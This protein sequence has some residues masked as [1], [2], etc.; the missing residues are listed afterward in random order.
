MGRVLFGVLR[1]FVTHFS[2]NAN[3]EPDLL[4]SLLLTCDRLIMM[5]A[6][7]DEDMSRLLVIIDRDTF[8]TERNSHLPP[9][10]VHIKLPE[11]VKAPIVDIFSHICDSVLR[12]RLITVAGF[13]DRFIKHAV[14]EEKHV[15]K[16]L[17]A[18]NV[19]FEH[20]SFRTDNHR[21]LKQ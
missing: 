2:L 16:L 13:A 17:A 1:Q 10:L 12:A 15:A 18:Q 19:I 3:S 21:Q 6:M 5:H 14:Q 4:V 11:R 8:E 9:G 20:G 7:G